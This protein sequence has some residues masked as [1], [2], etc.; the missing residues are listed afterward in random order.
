M[1]SIKLKVLTLA[2]LMMLTTNLYATTTNNVETSATHIN[3]ST[4][5][6]RLIGYTVLGEYDNVVAQGRASS[7]QTLADTDGDGY[8]SFTLSSSTTKGSLSLRNDGTA[9]VDVTVYSS[10]TNNAVWSARVNPGK[11]ETSASNLPLSTGK[12]YFIV[13]SDNGSA[14][15]VTCSARY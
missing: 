4:A 7:D 13:V 2:S 6:N 12:Y 10:E 8:F 3:E 14:L 5:D 15:N 9:R 1:K 11:S